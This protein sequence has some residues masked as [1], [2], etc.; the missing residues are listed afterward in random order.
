MIIQEVN[1]EGNN[2]IVQIKMSGTGDKIIQEEIIM[3]HS[4]FKN[5]YDQGQKETIQLANCLKYLIVKY[6]D[7]IFSNKNKNEMEVVFKKIKEEIDNYEDEDKE[8]EKEEEIK[9]ETID[10]LSNENLKKLSDDAKVELIMSKYAVSNFYPKKE[11]DSENKK[12]YDCFIE[13]IK[14]K[15]KLLRNAGYISE[16]IPFL[17]QFLSIVKTITEKEV[18]ERIVNKENKENTNNVMKIVEKIYN[19]LNSNK[20]VEE[21]PAS[22]PVKKGK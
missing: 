2:G 5:I 1:K 16:E 22:E 18:L 17:V 3:L 6:A 12:I 20:K 4:M 8:K 11:N 19:A 21:K 15:L 10:E 7:C 9:S 13:I 14:E